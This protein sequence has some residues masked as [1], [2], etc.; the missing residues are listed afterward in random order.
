VVGF[1]PTLADQNS[2][3]GGLA[4]SEPIPTPGWRRVSP[5]LRFTLLSVSADIPIVPIYGRHFELGRLQFII[6][7]TYRRSRERTVLAV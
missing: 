3:A 4:Q 5:A 2:N 6:T 7:S 1:A